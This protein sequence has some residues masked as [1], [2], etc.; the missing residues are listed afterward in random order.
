MNK[1]TNLTLLKQGIGIILTIT[2]IFV[3]RHY[4]L[5][6]TLPSS[7]HTITLVFTGIAV[8]LIINILCYA[9]KLYDVREVLWGFPALCGV[10][11]VT[12][13]VI[14]F[15]G[16]DYLKHIRFSTDTFDQVIMT[17]TQSLMTFI[18]MKWKKKKKPQNIDHELASVLK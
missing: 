10:T 3:F 11:A 16:V 9:A 15:G 4:G 1:S 13:V 18:I 17:A 6:E 7:N 5:L 12:Y 14:C 8:W 2:L